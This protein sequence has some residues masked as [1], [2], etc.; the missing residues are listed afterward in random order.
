MREW[1]LWGSRLAAGHDWNLGA[2]PT[3]KKGGLKG[4]QS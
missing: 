3:F 2:K 4:R 1:L